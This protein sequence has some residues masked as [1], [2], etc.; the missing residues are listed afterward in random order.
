MSEGFPTLGRELVR[1]WRDRA[2]T[3]PAAIG[4]NPTQEGLLLFER[5]HPGTPANVLSFVASVPAPLDMERLRSAL[6]EVAA[7]H[8]IL[9]SIFPSVD[10]PEVAVASCVVPPEAVD[11]SHL[12][13][14]ERRAAALADAEMRAAQQIDLAVGPLW[15]VAVWALGDE[16]IFQIV[17]HHIIADGWSLGVFLAEMST[18]YSGG[19]LPDPE[20]FPATTAT[21]TDRDVLYWRDRLAETI[22]LALP[23]DRPRPESRGF[24]SGNVPVS[25]DAP[26]LCQVL[27][28]AERER[29]TPFMVF[30]S[31]LHLTLAKV[32]GQTDVAI[33][34]PVITRERHQARRA[35]GPL[36]NMVV[37]RTNSAGACS[38]RE[39]LRAVRDTC[40]GAYGHAHV[41]LESIGARFQVM[42]E[43]QDG[44]P[45]LRMDGLPVKPLLMAPAGIQHDLALHLWKT[46]DGVAGFLGYD[47]EIFE[48]DTARLLAQ[49]FCTALRALAADPDQD[50]AEVDIATDAERHR[51]TELGAGCVAEVPWMCVHELV[52]AQV[53][54]TPE[55]VALRAVDATL[56]YRELD[57]QANRLAHHLLEIGVGQGAVVG[58]CLPRTSQLVISMLAVLKAGAAY[59]PVDPAYPAERVAFLLDDTHAAV[60]LTP[61]TYTL[62]EVDTR[63]ANRAAPDDLAYTIY[64]SGS[65]GRPKGVM[66]EHRQVMA[67]LNW[68]LR[69][70]TPEVLAQTLAATSI[71]FDL[72]V[73]EIFAPLASGATVTLAPT[74]ALD[75]IHHPER[76]SHLTLINSV[77][78]VARE[79][80]AAHAIPP[81]VRTVNLAGEPL[82]PELVR[83]LYAQPSIATVHN[84]Y[85]PSEDT[86]YSTHA[87]TDPNHDRTPIGRPIDG[88]HAHLLDS[89]LRPVPLGSVGEL[90]MSGTGITRGYHN[91]PALTAE[92]YLPSPLGAG[93]RIYRTGDLARWR[94]DGQLDYLGRIDNQIKLRGHRIEPGEIEAVLRKQPSVADVVVVVRRERLIAYVVPAAEIDAEALLATVG[95]LLPEYLVPSQVAVVD[96]LPQTPNGKVD[97]G[98]LPDPTAMAPARQEAP[99]TATEKLIAEIWADLLGH[100]KVGLH[101]N[102]FALGGHSLLVSRMVSRL[103]AR[104][105]TALPL[106]LVF[107]HPTVAEL[108]RH[109]PVQH[110]ASTAIPRIPRTTIG[111]P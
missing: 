2:A 103:T 4:V 39:L 105:G 67:L 47:T 59:V 34:S 82:P 107:D 35:I 42:C 77:P 17:A 68:A 8:P 72:S 74:N 23:T 36:V 75:L 101:D 16:T 66:V 95:R 109:L 19:S 99:T 91:R 65:T 38:G 45:E 51:L 86:T 30:L 62:S 53:D 71:C 88:T 96:A 31:A 9:R 40:L 5:I 64:T 37:L 13:C 92:R 43:L 108:A 18:L 22:P 29:L 87:V 98:A 15:R 26:T 1:R 3:G 85:G 57:T 10:P 93:Q 41:P 49:R 89:T 102:F 25:V 79:L 46:A 69:V 70:F 52:E 78:S 32:C 50:L 100:P 27:A 11:L 63:P 56:T 44:L 14:E 83:Q 20:P 97:R 7:R 106:R 73:Y 58:I 80:L 33:G 81:D 84:L 90:Y 21:V 6:M 111:D 54:Q 28:V 110:V 61:D 12:P 76:Y 60:L 24:R 55:A 104:T 48:V 94:A